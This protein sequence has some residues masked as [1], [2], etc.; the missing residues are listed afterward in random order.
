MQGGP[1][2]A[3][4][5]DSL[6]PAAVRA[7][8]RVQQVVTIPSLGG[9]L[10]EGLLATAEDGLRG[11]ERENKVKTYL[12]KQIRNVALA[13]SSGSGKTMLAEAML[14][15]AG[16]T[17]RLGRIEAGS[18][19]CDFE[20]E[21]KESGSSQ[22]TALASFEWGGH[23][24]NLLDAPGSFDFAGEQWAALAVADLVVLVV[25][26]VGGVDYGLVS[27]WRKAA[28]LGVPRLFFV[29]KLDREHISFE[30]VL[31]ELRET[32]GGGVAPVELPVDEGPGFRGVVDLLGEEAWLYEDGVSTSAEIPDELV[33]GA[34]SV[35]EALVEGIV[36]S[37]DEL[38]ERYLEG[39][40][41]AK[42]ELE[43]A[44][45]AGVAEAAV[46]PVVCGSAVT[47]IGVDRLCEYICTL[48][49]SPL[50]RP[51]MRTTNGGIA[52]AVA[53]APASLLVFKTTVD[54]YLGAI[55]LFRL[56]CGALRADDTLTNMRSGSAERMR[57]LLR[58]MGNE[59][60]PAGEL[61]AGDMGAAAKLSD[62]GTGDT[63]NAGGDLRLAPPD[64]PK[65]MFS[66]AVTPR[67]KLDE[68]KLSTS[69]RRICG[70]DPSL[71]VTRNTE[72]QQTLI[73]GL[74]ERHLRSA[75]RRIERKFNVGVDVEELL[76]PFRET[77]TVAASAEG[78]HKKQTGGHGQF[79]VAHVRL[80]PLPRGT[81][82]EFV[83]EITGGVIP[84]QFIPAVE[85]GI[86]EAM[87]SGGSHGHRVVDL[88]ATVFDGKHHSVDSSEMSFKLAGRLA[89]R[90]AMA[91]ARP[92]VLEPVSQVEVTAPGE[93]LGD[94]MGDL[95]ARR[96]I[97]QGTDPGQYGQQHV[98]AL[99]P[100]S[101]LVRY[102]IDL[103]SITGGRGS[104]TAS[105]DH[106]AALP[107]GC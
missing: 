34:A 38:L 5:A 29:N 44:F 94:V 62:T 75:L 8:R 59:T 97:V 42:G 82:F 1:D 96:G 36:E 47:P 95:S 49:P 90:N 103:R 86:K 71:S 43:A 27:S 45:S 98:R 83:D 21:E 68:E 41:P 101:E 16:V 84:R 51:G 70:E 85:A 107:G 39:D 26:A 80:E 54:P 30:K 9:N 52:P 17:T 40:V 67:T 57:T 28:E 60:E 20:P 12:S 10:R 4:N 37:D 6:P 65:P 46:F 78:K 72:T 64:V 91:S 74:G 31:G 88:R 100:E 93:C 76:I 69:L 48:G 102:A 25:D 15:R 89:F 7:R 2:G 23:K 79:G 18:T 50:A 33:D 35:G 14:F 13:G 63:L 53:D 105:H 87:E 55:S 61:C 66:F 77:I 19:V 22:S 81:G 73:S 104:F 106:Y 24:I 58:M 92:V 32:F 3:P 11:R 99:V 56:A